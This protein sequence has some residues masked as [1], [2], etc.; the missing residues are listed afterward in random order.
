[1][2]LDISGIDIA[3]SGCTF[4]SAI[5]SDNNVYSINIG[6]S[7]AILCQGITTFS[8]CTLHKPDNLL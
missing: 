5:I 1:M 8:L 7:K 6:D 4:L 2:E 3:F